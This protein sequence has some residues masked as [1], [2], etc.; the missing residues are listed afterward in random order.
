M[1]V[2]SDDVARAVLDEGSRVTLQL[3]MEWRRGWLCRFVVVSDI[4]NF[5][6]VRSTTHPCMHVC[7]ETR[8]LRE[9]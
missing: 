5:V 4:V 6:K 3:V 8:H 9:A 1:P 2:R 7:V